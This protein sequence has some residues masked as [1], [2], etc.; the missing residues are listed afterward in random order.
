VAGSPLCR[1]CLTP[2]VAGQSVCAHCG[3]RVGAQDSLPTLRGWER[4][5]DVARQVATGHTS[6]LGYQ[7]RYLFYFLVVFGMSWIA[8]FHPAQWPLLIVPVSI[9]LIIY[10]GTRKKK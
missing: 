5:E 6:R 3:H 4:P 10:L 7:Y 1:H 8:I 9:W 2:Y